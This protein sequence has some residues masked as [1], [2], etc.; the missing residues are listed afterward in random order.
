MT[1]EKFSCD[2]KNGNSGLYTGNSSKVRFWSIQR[3]FERCQ[4]A[5]SRVIKTWLHAAL[6]A[7]DRFLLEPIVGPRTLEAG[8]QLTASLA[9]HFRD[10]ALPLMLIVDHLPNL[11]ATVQAFGDVKHC[12]RKNDRDRFKRPRLRLRVDL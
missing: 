9:I 12:R 2:I 1:V 8:L 5:W 6:V 4:S 7:K 3:A 11:Q 10:K